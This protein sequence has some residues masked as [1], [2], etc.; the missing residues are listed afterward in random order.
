MG[1]KSRGNFLVNI[2]LRYDCM[3]QEDKDVCDKCRHFSNYEKFK[4]LNV[5]G[6]DE[7]QIQ[8]ET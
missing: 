1:Y 4:K 5:I 7:C 8:T 2:C 6:K 3:Y